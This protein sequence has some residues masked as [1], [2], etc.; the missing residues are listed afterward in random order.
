M[1]RLIMVFSLIGTVILI[2]IC[3]PLSLATKTTTPCPA[4]YLE[5]F[6]KRKN[7]YMQN[8]T[9]RDMFRENIVS[10][11]IQIL[12]NHGMNDDEIKAMMLKDFS[13]SEESL[14]MLFKEAQK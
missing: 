11:S 3:T 6:S 8:D 5:E 10:K 4:N 12:Q 1:I 7:D 13:I 2:A 14:D 9:V